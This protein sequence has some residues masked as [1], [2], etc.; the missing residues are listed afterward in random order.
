MIIVDHGMQAFSL[1]GN[2]LETGVKKGD[3]VDAGRPLGTV[4]VSVGGPSGLY[5]DSRIDGQPVDPLQWPE[6]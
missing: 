5:F 4:G 2:L 6:G 1:Y 3:F